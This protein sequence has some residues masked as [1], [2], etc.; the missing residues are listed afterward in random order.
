MGIGFGL[1][2]GYSDAERI[3]N[4]AAIPG[5]VIAPAFPSSPSPPAA[6]SSSPFGLIDSTIEAVKKEASKIGKE[7][8][9]V[10]EKITQEVKKVE[11]KIVEAAKKEEKS[12]KRI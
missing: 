9:V 1:G 5:F 10:D 4:P 8:A 12:Q 7:V 3:F 11:E 2:Q 6:S